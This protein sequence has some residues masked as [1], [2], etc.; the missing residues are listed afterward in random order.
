VSRQNWGARRYDRSL[1]ARPTTSTMLNQRH[2]ARHLA[3][4]STDMKTIAKTT[5]LEF[6]CRTHGFHSPAVSQTGLATFDVIQCV[7]LKKVP[8]HEKTNRWLTVLAFPSPGKGPCKRSLPVTP[9]VPHATM[10]IIPR[11]H[12]VLDMGCRQ[13]ERPGFLAVVSRSYE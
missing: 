3:A 10:E 8:L 4:Q 6:A 13:F 9:T 11:G 2:P 1:L 12:P 7:A 5:C